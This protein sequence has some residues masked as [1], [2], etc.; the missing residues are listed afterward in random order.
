M[1]AQRG[2]REE[3]DVAGA[4]GLERELLDLLVACAAGVGGTPSA[5]SPTHARP[6]G[7]GVQNA[8][9]C[10][11]RVVACASS[12]VSC[13]TGTGVVSLQR[14]TGGVHALCVAAMHG[15]VLTERGLD[16]LA[17]RARRRKELE[18]GHGE[19]ALA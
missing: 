8:P 7:G 4:R 6:R 17:R 14:C 18:L 12:I 13:R 15:R 9:A 5:K 2:D 11:Q 3:D 16:V 10:R 1:S 19:V